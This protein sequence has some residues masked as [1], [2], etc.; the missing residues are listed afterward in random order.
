M[1]VPTSRAGVSL[2]IRRHL[3]DWLRP[4][5][6]KLRR[7]YTGLM[8]SGAAGAWYSPVRT[9]A[10]QLQAEREIFDGQT[11]VHELP[12]IFH[13][14]SN[15]YLRPMFEEYGFSNPDQFFAKYLFEA[16]KLSAGEAAKFLSV[17]SGNCDT[18][19]RVACL[20][21]EAG[22]RDFTIECLD[23]SP[24]MLAR[25]KAD[26]QARGVAEHLLFTEVDF[27]RWQSSSKY[28][29]IMA[30]Q[31]LHHVLELEHL[32]D[33]VKNALLP[34]GLF[35]TSDMI[36]R[37]GHMRWPES[38]AAVQRFWQELPDAY[39]YNVQLRRHEPTYKNWDCS[40]ESFEGIRAQD[41]LPELIKRFNFKLFIPAS[42]VVDIF[43]DR[44]FGHHFDIHKPADLDFID[45]LHA[46][47][48]QALAS[49]ELTPTRL[50]AVMTVEEGPGEYSRGLQPAR[51][52]R[53]A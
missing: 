17:G 36:G 13:Y 47:D 7:V 25:G 46:Y 37:N 32:F 45:R 26:A 9:Y 4:A 34:Q 52:V 15:K 1:A 40:S 23:L 11:E 14:W 43:I 18:E 29:A 28:H 41:V 2:L 48:E 33:A 51:C 24:A 8:H 19:V 50:V 44:S 30:N 49:G 31:S 21:K 6:R 22:L 53:K 42:S 16:G 10:S 20:L 3:P 12:E 35:I 5:A 27:N 39:R 38:L